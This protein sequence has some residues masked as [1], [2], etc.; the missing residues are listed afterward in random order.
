[1]VSLNAA[2][3]SV[4]SID[5]KE[6]IQIQSSNLRVSSPPCSHLSVCFRLDLFLSVG[7]SV[8]FGDAQC[9]R[10]GERHRGAGEKQDGRMMAESDGRLEFEVV[11]AYAVGSMFG[12]KNILLVPV[13]V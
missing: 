10:V 5:A 4:G 9:C 12:M 7:P 13:P 1:V 6:Q 3:F 11:P 2:M 8:Q